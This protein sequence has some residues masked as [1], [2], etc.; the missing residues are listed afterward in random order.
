[1]IVIA[2]DRGL[3]GGFNS[4]ILKLAYRRAKEI[5]ETGKTVEIVA[6]GKKSVEYFEKREFIVRAKY[7]ILV[8]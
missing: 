4:N 3:A 8:W 6:I 2:G 1:M 7:L 5:S